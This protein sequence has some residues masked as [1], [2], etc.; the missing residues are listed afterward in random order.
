MAR[1]AVFLDR[2][3]T[4]V[5][6]VDY[7]ASP[8]QLRLLP[9]AAAAIRRLNEAGIAVVLTTN[10]SGIARGLL[11]EAGLAGIHALLQ[12]RLARHGARLDAIYYC[13]HHPES[14]ARP[15]RRRCRCRK[16]AP[17][18]LRRAARDLNLAL[19]RSYAIG[20]SPRDVDAGR[21]V[22]CRTALVRTGHGRDA[23]R[24]HAATAGADYV[25]DDLFDAVCWILARRRA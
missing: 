20:D 1:P 3:G 6:E 9:R 7:M 16:P 12:R 13:P 15:Y 2:D 22:G 23:E 14:G 17:G 21:R 11:T 19:D 10:Q 8:A 24:D 25:A 4:V 5:R 18:M